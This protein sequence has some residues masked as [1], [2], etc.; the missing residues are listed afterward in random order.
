MGGRFASIVPAQACPG[1]AFPEPQAAALEGRGVG[2]SGRP[3]PSRAPGFGVALTPR[4]VGGWGGGGPFPHP[5]TQLSQDGP[6]LLL[7]VPDSTYQVCCPPH[8]SWPT[9]LRT[10]QLPPAP[11]KPPP[12]LPPASR[13]TTPT[14]EPVATPLSRPAAVSSPLAWK[15]LGTTLPR[16]CLG[17]H[18]WSVNVCR[19]MDP[20]LV[21]WQ[22]GGRSEGMVPG[23]VHTAVWWASGSVG[24][25]WPGG[26]RTHCGVKRWGGLL[27]IQGSRTWEAGG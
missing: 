26:L 22:E 19:W 23:G 3:S 10:R 25:P 6:R 11:L 21:Q 14:S 8:A 18:A 9:P 16:E 5:H 15:L 20:P 4:G 12:V 17:P 24:G 7:G 27:G 13:H 1:R 2:V